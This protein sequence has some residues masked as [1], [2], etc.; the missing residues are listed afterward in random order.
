M[1]NPS[2]VLSVAGIEQ[3]WAMQALET[4]I[5]KGVPE[6]L[7]GGPRG[8]GKTVFICDFLHRLCLRYAGMRQL[9]TRSTRTRLTDAALFTFEEEVLGKSHP[10]LGNQDRKNRT[11]YLYPNGS[12]IV[13][14]GMDDPQRQRSVGVDVVWVNEPTE[15][16]ESAWE[17]AGFSLRETITTTCPFRLQIG[18]HNPAPPSHFTNQRVK[19]FPSRLY[20]RV[21][22]DGTR[23][24]EWFTP[25]MYADTCD[26]NFSDQSQFKAHKVQTFHADNPAYWDANAWDWTRA[27]LEYVKSRLGKATG[28]RKAR[29]L[30]GRPVAD[31]GTVFGD[32]FDRDRN[33]IPPFDIGWPIE[34]PVWVGYDPG[35]AH[36]CAVVF[37]GVAPNGQHHI[38]DEIHGRQ[39]DIDALGRAIQAKAEKYRI[40]SWLDDPRGANQRT[41]VANGKTVRDHMREKFQLHFRPWQAAEGAGKQAQVESIRLLLI[42]EKLPL[43]VWDT[44]VGVISE[45]ETWR[46][47]TDIKGELL[48]GDDAYEDK[49]NDAMDAIMGIVAANPVFETSPIVS[50]TN[51]QT[52]DARSFPSQSGPGG[53]PQDR[54]LGRDPHNLNRRWP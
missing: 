18:D 45:F 12:E 17:E 20:P 41:Q 52:A 7:V 27:G 3:R 53:T 25:S 47:K 40:V 30:E 2:R 43:L 22:D 44:C 14:Q 13:L 31:E 33:V 48:K 19:P 5:A 35:Y 54:A 11:N 8:T 36:P 28:A 26:W 46:N 39:I 49:N 32:D 38:I 23:M 4:A 37:W 29:N 51:N 24:R 1:S 10:L 9:W 50:L 6:I 42:N 16:S 34:W 15:I 21:Q